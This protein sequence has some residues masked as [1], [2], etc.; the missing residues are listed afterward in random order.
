MKVSFEEAAQM[1]IRLRWPVFP[2]SVDKVPL[3]KHGYRDATISPRQI[4]DWS[5]RFQDANIAIATGR[6]SGVVVLDVDGDAGFESLEHLKSRGLRFPDG[7]SSKTGRGLHIYMKHDKVMKS[8]VSKLGPGLDIRADG[9]SIIAPPSI[10][11]SGVEYTWI[12]SPEDMPLAHFPMAGLLML[13]KPKVRVSRPAPH[14]HDL[15]ELT[16]RVSRAQPGSR[17]CELNA[18]AYMAGRL[19]RD[20]LVTEKDALSALIQAAMASGLPERESRITARSGI[21]AGAEA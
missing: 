5:K 12:H 10:H 17:N 2:V 9:G 14:Q 6:S 16:D 21:R 7:P 1:Y 13:Y 18:A 4:E 11:A 19:V 3:T 8:S 15:R 20:G